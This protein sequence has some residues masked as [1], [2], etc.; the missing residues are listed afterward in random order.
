M[1]KDKDT[2]TYN[3]KKSLDVGK[4]SEGEG[5]SNQANLVRLAFELAE[6]SIDNEGIENQK[7]LNRYIYVLIYRSN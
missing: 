6:N 1:E 2:S 4:Y 3:D 7:K 5:G